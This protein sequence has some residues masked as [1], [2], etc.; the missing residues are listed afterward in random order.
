MLKLN[1]ETITKVLTRELG[2]RTPEF[3]LRRAGE[4]IVGAIVSPTFHGHGD[5][6]RQSEI[7]DALDGAFGPV[8]VRR[9]GMLLA[10]TPDEWNVDIEPPSLTKRRSKVRA[11]AK[12]A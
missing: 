6:Q 12:A 5:H 9:V 4:L 11:R 8:A 10:Y 2:L 7:W 1:K 3:H